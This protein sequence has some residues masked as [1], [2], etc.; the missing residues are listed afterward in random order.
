[1]CERSREGLTVFDHLLE[2]VDEIGLPKGAR[3]LEGTVARIS[4]SSMVSFYQGAGSFRAESGDTDILACSCLARHGSVD[5]CDD[6]FFDTHFLPVI[7]RMFG[8]LLVTL[9]PVGVAH[10]R[11]V[12]IALQQL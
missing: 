7:L 8:P 12:L 2:Q 11:Y 6:A 4:P 9:S 5:L 3:G 10:E 1:M